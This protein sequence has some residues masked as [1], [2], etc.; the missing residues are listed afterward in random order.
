MKTIR[1]WIGRLLVRLG[2]WVSPNGLRTFV[3]EIAEGDDLTRL[4]LQLGV[5][6]ETDE[7]Y[8]A[9][10]EAVIRSPR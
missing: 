7:E 3:F 4:G 9:R 6:R 10:V 8:R 1:L 5:P 2:L